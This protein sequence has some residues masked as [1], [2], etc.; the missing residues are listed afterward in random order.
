M[1]LMR[2]APRGLFWTLSATLPLGRFATNEDIAEMALFLCSPGAS[3]V[4]GSVVV[5]DGGMS[6]VGFTALMPR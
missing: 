1:P 4:T 3:Y 6:L 5:V 2:F